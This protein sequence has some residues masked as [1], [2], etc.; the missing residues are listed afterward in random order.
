MSCSVVIRLNRSCL[1]E[2]QHEADRCTPLETGGVLLGR[3]ATSTQVD[4]LRQIGPGPKA[5]HSPAGFSPDQLYQETQVA[6]VFRDTRG[7]IVYLGDWHS[8]PGS[9]AVLSRKDR[10][11]LILIATSE[12]A[13][14][15]QPLMAILAGGDPWNYVF[16]KA[17]MVRRIWG[18]ILRTQRG[19]VRLVD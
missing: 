4:V 8:H 16:W 3:W 14:A 15:P 12:E 7:E 10:S 19:Q 13:R 18:K 9:E 6:A 11:A 1:V 2:M 17:W 5:T